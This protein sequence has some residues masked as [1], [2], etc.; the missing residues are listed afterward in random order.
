MFSLRCIY[1]T[2][3]CSLLVLLALSTAAGDI[4]RYRDK[5]GVWHF[6]NVKNDKRYKLYIRTYRKKVSQYIKDYEGIIVQASRKFNVDPS[7]IKAV[8]KA[9]SDF[10]HRAVSQKGAKGLMQLMP[11]T[12]DRMKVEDPFNPE[13]NIFGG[14][15]YLSLMLKRF[16]NRKLALAA[17]NAGPE[18]IEQY[19]G[20]PPFPETRAFVKKVLYYYS[21]YNSGKR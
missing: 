21:Q 6:T 14:T 5:N 12:A 15:R 8:I 11:N 19:Q 20:I 16:K 13:E 17:Y 1:A 4:Y 18:S 10:D 7:L 3:I 2:G 9:E